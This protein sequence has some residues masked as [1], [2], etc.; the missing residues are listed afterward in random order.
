MNYRLVSKLLGLLL[1]LLS[2][3]MLSCLVYAWWH[4]ERTPGLDAVEAFAASNVAS[5]LVGL[6]LITFGKGSGREMLRKEAV[7]VVGLGWFVC[8]AFGALPYILCEPSLGPAAAFF[9][10]VSGFTTTGSSVIRDLDAL[11][12]SILLW[13]SLTQ[14]LGGLGILVLFVALLSSLGAGSKALFHHE[15]SA[16][17]GGGLQARI[18]DVATRFLQI[19]TGLTIVC[20]GGLM[21]MGMN[22]Y[23]S[24]CHAMTTLST[25]G[26]SPRNTSIAAYH[27]L[28]IELWITLFMLL[29]GISFMLYAWLLRGRW[30]RW[31]T[32]EETKVFLCIIA[33]VTTI[34][35]TN[36]LL[37]GDGHTVISAFRD[38]LFQ[39]VS[40]ITTTGFVS[41]DYDVWPSL[42]RL[43]LL[44]LM[45]IGGC[46]GST[47]GGIKV[48]RWILFFKIVRHEITHSYRPKQVFT[49]RLNGVIAEA[50]LFLQT[51]FFIALA[52]VT[53]TIGTVVVSLLEP[54]MS[55]DGCLSSV[56]ATLFNIGPGLAKVGPTHTFAH[57]G[58]GTLFFLSLLMLLGRLEFFAVLV[59][60]MPSLWRRY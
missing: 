31:K 39:V 45:I 50:E 53:V 3:A 18:Q 30:D 51:I 8:A 43:L 35:A 36:L 44:S 22:P 55:I 25:G 13:R 57:F 19:Y 12:R 26:F 58:G 10:S 21:L 41:T 40:I 27:S 42:S 54:G 34:I 60:F 48:S 37:V 20:A 33:G 29:G 24:V 4:H 6:I 17:N 56:L 59:L 23:E 14:W 32:D 16:K 7:A 46:A 28:A 52:G 5:T 9:E 11:P 1:L 38:G 15:Y 49:L 47:A 2:A